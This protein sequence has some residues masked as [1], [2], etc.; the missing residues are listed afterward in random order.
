MNENKDKTT[1]PETASPK[2]NE[3]YFAAKPKKE[4]LRRGEQKVLT[5]P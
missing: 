2:K 1:S 5:T 3:E 4:E